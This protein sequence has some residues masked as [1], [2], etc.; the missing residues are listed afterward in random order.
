MDI[1]N[2][3]I[4]GFTLTIVAYLIGLVISKKVKF[5]LFNPLIIATILIIVLLSLFKI[6]YEVYNKGGSIVT[7]FLGPATVVLAVPL[8][9]QIDNFLKN[10]IPVLGGIVVGSIV[11]IV[12]IIYLSK[13]IGLD[14]VLNLSLVPK[15]TTTAISQGISGQI[16][17]IPSISVAATVITGVS[18]NVMGAWLFKIFKISDEIAR[19]VAF[20]TGAHA[21][22]TAKAMEE[23]EIQG[24][25]ASLSIGLMGLVTVFLA[26]LIVRLLL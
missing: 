15:S 1:L 17:G 6:D 14:R 11:S 12:A 9:K 22:G 3:P 26:P 7:F 18:G 20:G 8:Y 21:I 2:T 5:T 23:G 25:M 16:G 19:G 13:F 10:G 24:A 4:F